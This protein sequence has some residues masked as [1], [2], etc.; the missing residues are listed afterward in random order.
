MWGRGLTLPWE[1][2]PV[3]GGPCGQTGVGPLTEGI[4]AA[5]G[6]QGFTG[7]PA[8]NEMDASLRLT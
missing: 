4:E 5:S 1:I 2:S 6:V 3:I 7:R 8:A